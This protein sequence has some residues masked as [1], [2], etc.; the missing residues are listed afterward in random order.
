MRKCC[1][2]LSEVGGGPL[3]FGFC[4]A[5]ADRQP[6]PRASSQ[7]L[8]ALPGCGGGG[9]VAKSGGFPGSFQR[10]NC[11]GLILTPLQLPSQVARPTQRLFVGPPWWSVSELAVP[12]LP[13]AHPWLPPLQVPHA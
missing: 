10:P 5:P 8:E 13:W 9:R 4:G 12:P 11:L 1:F 3:G 6:A 2:L 7:D